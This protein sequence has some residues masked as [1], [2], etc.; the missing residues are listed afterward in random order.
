M[1]CAAYFAFSGAAFVSHRSSQPEVTA[2]T[3][4]PA[5]ASE[6]MEDSAHVAMRQVTE[7]PSGSLVDSGIVH[8]CPGVVCGI[9][10]MGGMELTGEPVLPLRR[11]TVV[12]TFQELSAA[13]TRLEMRQQ[14]L[15]DA[16]Y[17][18]SYGYVCVIWSC[19]TQ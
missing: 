18:P 11:S 3:L 13:L 2:I 10:R 8:T 16:E 5:W 7:S 14:L 12:T 9:C 4:L 19:F 6:L 17:G 15:H 1:T